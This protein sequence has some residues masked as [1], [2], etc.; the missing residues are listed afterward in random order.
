MESL[1]MAAL[2]EAVSKLIGA[3][4]ALALSFLVASPKLAVAFFSFALILAA[5]AIGE[6]L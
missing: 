2:T 3:F 4:A 5:L 6:V 1:P